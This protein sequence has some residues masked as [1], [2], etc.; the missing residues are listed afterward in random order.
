MNMFPNMG[1]LKNLFTRVYSKIGNSL[2]VTLIRDKG[3]IKRSKL[4]S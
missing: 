2:N 1:I 4:F 3:E